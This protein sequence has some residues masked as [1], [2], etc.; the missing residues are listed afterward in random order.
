MISTL[1][2]PGVGI[3]GL[4]DIHLLKHGRR[5]LNNP[6][7]QSH[8]PMSR[9]GIMKE[10]KKARDNELQLIYLRYFDLDGLKPKLRQL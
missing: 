9:V 10:K 3:F 8:Q 5:Q 1:H 4:A 7:C 6:P 2:I